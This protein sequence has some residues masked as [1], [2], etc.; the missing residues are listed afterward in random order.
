MA[1]AR[2]DIPT[3]LVIGG[4][5]ACGKVAGK[6]VDIEDVFESVGELAA[7]KISIKD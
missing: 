6:K 1:A 5:Q 2:L 7:K 4:Y 3:I